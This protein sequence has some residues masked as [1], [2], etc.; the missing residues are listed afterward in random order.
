LGAGEAGA[1]AT[2]VLYGAPAPRVLLEV[3]FSPDGKRLAGISR[4]VIK[5][6]DAE[7]G[8][9]ILTLRGATQRYWDSPFNPRVAFSPDGAQ[10]AGTNWDE[11]FS[12]WDG[13]AARDT[14]PPE[15]R[16]QK[17]RRAARAL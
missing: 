8:R 12:L 13:G 9:G 5:L 17:R 7:A 4:D 10:L 1:L 2:R 16:R 3:A 14:D 11:S 6:W 15:V